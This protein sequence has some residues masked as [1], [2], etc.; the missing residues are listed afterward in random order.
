[1]QYVLE[2]KNIEK[3]Y[4]D[5]HKKEVSAIKNFTAGFEKGKFYAVMGPSGAGKS[6]ILSIMG[7]MEEKTGGDM[8]L[9][10]QKINLLTQRE[11]AVVRREKIGFVFQHYFLNP[12]LT[13]MDNIILPMKINKKISRKDYKNKAVELLKYFGIEKYADRFPD[14]ISGGEQQ[15][16][17]I[18][19]ALANNPE[20]ILADEPTGNLDE[21]NEKTVLDT[22]KRL[23][24][25]GKTVIIVSHSSTVI[26]YADK[27]LN[28]R[29]G[30]LED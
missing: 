10:G 19:R 18:A 4:V 14:E 5:A 23:S 24:E 9:E 11:M 29:E 22:L 13:V 8:Y 25:E 26:K 30:V 21:D 15:R 20:I 3:K 1:M 6:T 27:V 16:V 12:K 28:I 2:M 7:F 17:C